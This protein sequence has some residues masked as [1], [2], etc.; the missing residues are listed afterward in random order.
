MEFSKTILSRSI[1]VASY[2]STLVLVFFLPFKDDFLPVII[3]VWV[4]IWLFEL[5][6]K[7]RFKYLPSKLLYLLFLTYFLLTLFSTLL[8]VPFSEGIQAIQLK[9]SFVLFPLIFAGANPTI[10]NNHKSIFWAFI[11]GNLAASLLCI[12]IALGQHLHFQSGHIT[13][14]YWIDPYYK[15]YSFFD[16]IN[17]RANS[18]S[19]IHLSRFLHPSYFSMYLNFSLV[20]LYWLYKYKWIKRNYVKIF[21]LFTGFI[22]LLMIYLLQSRAGLISF[23]IT[24]VILGV[25]ELMKYRKRH[26]IIVFVILFVSVAIAIGNNKQFRMSVKDSIEILDNKDQLTLQKCDARLQT[27][28]ASYCV[29][30]ENFWF[31]TSPAALETELVKKYHQFHLSFAEKEKLNAHNQYLETFAGLGIF[32]FINLIGLLFYL[33]LYAFRQRSFILMELAGLLSVNFIF[34]SMLNRISGVIF[35]MVF[36]GLLIYARPK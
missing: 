33:A 1:S 35:M 36:V 16:L 32:G 12:F 4:L 8:Q 34:E 10:K 28:Y 3:S 22:F 13:L 14:E 15:K 23:I 21:S 17:L 31:G 18:F 7:T 20:L 6:F 9:L 27:I 29:I 19:Y 11:L 30:R 24:L 5:N 26:Q 2:F 25:S